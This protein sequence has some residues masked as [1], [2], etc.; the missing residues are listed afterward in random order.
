VNAHDN[1]RARQRRNGPRRAAAGVL[2]ALLAGIALLAAAC[3]GGLHPTGSTASPG[4]LTVAKLDAFAQCMRSHAVPDFYFSPASPNSSSPTN[5]LF[6]YAIPASIDKRSPQFQAALTACKPGLGLPSGPPP[7][8]TAAQLRSAL[9]AAE[10]MHAHGYPGYPDPR[11]ESGS[12]VVPPLPSSIDTNSPRFQAA[13][14]KCHPA[15]PGGQNV[16]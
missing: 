1:Y 4:Q 11:L 15:F 8:V 10:C 13:V 7:A 3:G 9:S 12:I 2:T 14:N 16:G 6:G 5:M